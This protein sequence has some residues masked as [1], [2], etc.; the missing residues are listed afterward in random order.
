MKYYIKNQQ[1]RNFSET[2]EYSPSDV[3]PDSAKVNL[4]SLKRTLR[5]HFI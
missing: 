2:I 1:L 4:K 5:M 3:G